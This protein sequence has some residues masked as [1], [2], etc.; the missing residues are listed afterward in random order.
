MGEAMWSGI[1][2]TWPVN[3]ARRGAEWVRLGA[4]YSLVGL[5]TGAAYRA[6]WG[7]ELGG[8]RQVMRRWVRDGVTGGRAP[9]SRDDVPLFLG[10]TDH[11]FLVVF[12]YAEGLDVAFSVLRER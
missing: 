8:G 1:H 11:P 4:A 9:F 2:P 12:F 3:A 10:T 7:W 6:G 5:G